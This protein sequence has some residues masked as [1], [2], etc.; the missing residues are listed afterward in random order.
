MGSTPLINWGLAFQTAIQGHLL[1]ILHGDTSGASPWLRAAE[2]LQ[3]DHF[4]ALSLNLKCLLLLLLKW[5][6]LPGEFI[7]LSSFRLGPLPGCSA[8]QG[9][10][11]RGSLIKDRRCTCPP[12][13]LCFFTV[14]TLRFSPSLESPSGFCLQL[15]CVCRQGPVLPETGE[16]LSCFISLLCSALAMFGAGGRGTAPE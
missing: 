10:D 16:L 8:F 4:P 15:T 11:C 5:P 14:F 9:S 12:F 13:C 6:L 1:C 3:T 7:N 2:V